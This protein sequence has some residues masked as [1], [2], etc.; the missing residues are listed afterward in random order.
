MFETLNTIID[1]YLSLIF[2]SKKC[3]AVAADDDDDSNAL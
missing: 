2:Q 3:H 1:H